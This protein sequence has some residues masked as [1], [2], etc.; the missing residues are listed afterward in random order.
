MLIAIPITTS[1]LN[2]LQH[3]GSVD[4]DHTIKSG[5]IIPVWMFS[6]GLVYIG[7]F[8]KKKKEDDRWLVEKVEEI[9]PKQ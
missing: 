3:K 6:I 9:G 8:L 7:A 5:F 2:I 4:F 1:I